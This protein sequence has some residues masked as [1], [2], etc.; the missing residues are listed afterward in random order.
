MRAGFSA[1]R[2]KMRAESSPLRQEMR[3][4]D[5]E[6]R[7]LICVL[8]EELVGRIALLRPGATLTLIAL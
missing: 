4:G 5:E 1:I 8:Q 6:T 7:R 2:E 3:N